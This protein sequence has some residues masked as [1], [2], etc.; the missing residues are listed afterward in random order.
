MYQIYLVFKETIRQFQKHNVSQMAASLA[1][2][3][4][5]ATAP[6]ILITITI[7][8][9]F[10]SDQ[11]IRYTIIN[12][13]R[14]A[15]GP[16]V[17]NTVQTIFIHNNTRS[18]QN[19]IFESIT[20]LTLLFA[21]TTL[22]VQLQKILDNLWGNTS[23]KKN[24]MIQNIRTRILSLLA[25]VG[26]GITLYVFFILSLAINL[27]GTYIES[28]TGYNPWLLQN[29]HL[30]SS[31]FFVIAVLTS[32]Y[33]FVPHAKIAWIDALQG[34]T[35]TAALFTLG[36]YFL[37]FYFSQNIIGSVY[38]TAGS[39]LVFLVWIYFSALIFLFG[40]KLTKV[41]AEKIGKGFIL[42]N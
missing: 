33:K 30:I 35:F 41:Y 3:G 23:P 5:F 32:I 40:A 29:I 17:A 12:E 24:T 15:A 25:I 37:T 10:L 34:G 11:Q 31:F 38:G 18:S 42:E 4:L 2:F 14:V 16:Q 6:I 7:L 26:A 13:V 22:F 8:N 20:I 36:Q 27:L 1:Y 19:L 28:Q 39:L 21:A 9:I